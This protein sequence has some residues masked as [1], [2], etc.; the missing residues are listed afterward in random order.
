MKEQEA[1]P[2]GFSVCPVIYALHLIGGKWQLP[3]IWVLNQHSVLRYNELKRRVCGITNMMLT[4]SLKQLEESGL[5]QRVQYQEIPPRVE[6][7]LTP[8]GKSLLPALDELA[9]WGRVQMEQQPMATEKKLRCAE[10][11]NR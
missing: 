8:A 10:C 5:I 9:E 3:I 7:S 2:G 1:S 4:Q 6:Y 11:R